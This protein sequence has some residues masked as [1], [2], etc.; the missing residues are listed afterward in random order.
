MQVKN[1]FRY[2][3]GTACWMVCFG[4]KRYQIPAL[5]DYKVAF[6]KTSSLIKNATFSVQQITDH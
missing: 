5:P 6:L 1:N 3:Q 2:S 4:L